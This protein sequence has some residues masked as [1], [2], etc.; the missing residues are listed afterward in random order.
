[1]RLGK[2]RS[3]GLVG[4]QASLV[5]VEVSVGGGLP[6]TVIVGL[7][8][9]AL[10]EAR[11]RCRAAISSSGFE[12]PQHLVTINLS[13]ASLPKSGTHFDLGIVGGILAA[14][15]S[16]AQGRLDDAVLIK[17]NHIALAGGLRTAVERARRHVGHLVKIEVEVDT[18]AQLEELIPL[19]VDA[20]LLDNMPPETLSRAVRMVDGRILTEASGNINAKT[21]RAVA[22][23]GVDMISVGWLTHSVTNFDVGLDFD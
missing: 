2:A 20:V 1:M 3:V 9:A 16:V 13:P 22:E 6:R 10:S 17:D 5:D 23:T 8:D 14:H 19:G 12:W 7:P 18:L 4:L 11:S 21:V 15:G